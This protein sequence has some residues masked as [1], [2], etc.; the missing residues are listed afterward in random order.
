MRRFLT[1]FSLSVSVASGVS[2]T[3]RL[4]ASTFRAKT[5]SVLAADSV[6]ESRRLFDV[7]RRAFDAQLFEMAA[8]TLSRAT[9]LNPGDSRIHLWLG[10][11]LAQQAMRANLPK[12]LLLSSRIRDAWRRAI[13]IDP[14]NVEAR[15]NLIA[16]YESVPAIAGGGRAKA[17][18]EA[19]EAQAVM[20]Y[21]GAVWLARVLERGNDSTGALGAY[22]DAA[23][24]PDDS[25]GRAFEGWL[26]GLSQFSR[27]AEV[28][29]AVDARLKR[30]PNDGIALAYLARTAARSATRSDDGLRALARAERLQLPSFLHF[31]AEFG[32]AWY[33]GKLLEEKRDFAGAAVAYRAALAKS[34]KDSSIARDLARVSRP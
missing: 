34:P 33:R 11:A 20:P 24:L 9:E 13:A 25:S 19:K 22:A 3:T 7:A 1:V 17:I 10:N 21:L 6:T 30:S 2:A 18:A 27:Y 8:D 26:Y 5:S 4:S 12:K 31:D 23:R 15:E 32:F 14:R 16:F 29:A 28:F